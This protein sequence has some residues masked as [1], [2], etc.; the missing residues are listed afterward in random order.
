MLQRAAGDEQRLE[1]PAGASPDAVVLRWYYPKAY[2]LILAVLPA[3]AGA[4][5]GLVR[6]SVSAFVAGLIVSAVGSALAF[7]I[8]GLNSLERFAFDGHLFW[9]RSFRTYQGPVDLKRLRAVYLVPASSGAKLFL[10]Q[11]DAGVSITARTSHGF[12]ADTVTALNASGTLRSLAVTANTSSMYP[13]YVAEIARHA[14]NSPA[15]IDAKARALFTRALAD[16][17]AMRTGSGSSP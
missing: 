17:Q 12:D 14:L 9:Y 16:E 10:L 4:I 2:W 15:V 1:R 7:V 13:G 3:V 11:D 5:I 8:V 6:A